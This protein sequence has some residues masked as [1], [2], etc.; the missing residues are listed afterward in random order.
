ME[1]SGAGSTNGFLVLP[2]QDWPTSVWHASPLVTLPAGTAYVRGTVSPSPERRSSSLLACDMRLIFRDANGRRV[3]G[4]GTGIV[5][6]PAFEPDE[7]TPVTGH[8]AGQQPGQF[9]A[10]SSGFAFV[11]NDSLGAQQ[12]VFGIS[13]GIEFQI[14][15]EQETSIQAAATVEAFDV[16][17]NSLEIVGANHA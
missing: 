7:T 14:S 16:D 6:R 9:P 4:S 5:P 1:T 8:E 11:V 3:Q 13:A 12:P 15:H 17:G 2:M 10:Q